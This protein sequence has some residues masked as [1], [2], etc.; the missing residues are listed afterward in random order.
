MLGLS[1]EVT[2][3]Y[4]ADRTAKWHRGLVRAMVGV[5]YDAGKARVVAEEAIRKAVTTKDN[6]ADLINVALEE[7]VRARCE[8]PGFSTLTGWSRRSGQRRTSRCTRWSRPGS[9]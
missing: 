1:S 9:T 7:L 6:P 5:K 2:A 3:E 4:D 8:L